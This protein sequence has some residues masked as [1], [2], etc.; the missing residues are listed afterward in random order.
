L[1]SAAMVVL[2]P[3]ASNLVMGPT[4]LLPS[5]KACH[6]EAKSLPTGVRR[7]RPVTATLRGGLPMNAYLA[8]RLLLMKSTANCTVLSFWAASSSIFMSNSSS[9]AMMS[10]TRSRESAP[11]SS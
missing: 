11:R 10:S 2:R 4:P 6:E 9:M 7:E 3:E 1:S 5:V 8:A